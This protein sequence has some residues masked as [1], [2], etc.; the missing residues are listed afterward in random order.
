MGTLDLA[1]E[2]WGSALD[3][4]MADALMPGMGGPISRACTAEDVGDLE[5]KRNQSLS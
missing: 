2:L 5:I 1:V 4:G 3:V